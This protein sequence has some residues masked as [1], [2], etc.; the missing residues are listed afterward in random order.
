MLTKQQKLD[1]IEARRIWHN[2][3]VSDMTVDEIVDDDSANYDDAQAA[4]SEMQ[5][6][7]AN[8]DAILADWT[9][10][11]H[12]VQSLAGAHQDVDAVQAVGGDGLIEQASDGGYWVS[13]FKPRQQGS[14]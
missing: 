10:S 8:G 3:A 6:Q 2:V 9:L 13:I 12:K 5:R 7:L 14:S 11:D 1:A 4:K